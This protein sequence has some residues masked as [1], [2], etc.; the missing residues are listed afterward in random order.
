M[1]SDAL[2]DL[3]R[4]YKIL[5]NAEAQMLSE[6]GCIFPA[7]RKLKDA[8]DEVRNAVLTQCAID[9]GVDA[10]IQQTNDSSHTNHYWNWYKE[11]LEWRKERKG[12]I[13]QLRKPDVKE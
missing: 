7:L 8:I 1:R 13:H 4:Q 11:F 6:C 9:L 3:L 2:Q 5:I 10:E 12:I